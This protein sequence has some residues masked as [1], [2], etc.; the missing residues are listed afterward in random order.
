VAGQ[1]RLFD[2]GTARMVRRMR[3]GT[4]RLISELRRRDQIDARDVALVDAVRTVADLIDAELGEV[5]PNKWTV[6]AGMR[7]WRAL[8]TELRAEAAAGIEDEL[9]AFFSDD[10]PT[11]RDSP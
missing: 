9:R 6:F 2:D 3:R 1:T 7:E 5:E 11:V 8:H 10:G 4:D